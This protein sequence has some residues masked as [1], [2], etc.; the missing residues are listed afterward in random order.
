MIQRMKGPVMRRVSLEAI[1][2]MHVGIQFNIVYW[3]WF[4]LQ[5]SSI[6]DVYPEIVFGCFRFR[7][8][9]SQSGNLHSAEK[10][11]RGSPPMLWCLVKILC[12]PEC[13]R[14]LF[15]VLKPDYWVI[16]F[17]VVRRWWSTGPSSLPPRGRRG[18]RWGR[19]GSRTPRGHVSVFGPSLAE[20]QLPTLRSRPTESL[21]RRRGRRRRRVRGRRTHGWGHEPSDTDREPDEERQRRRLRV[22]HIGTT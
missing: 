12:L 5:C 20:Q 10:P 14:K 8:L 2:Y 16:V 21:Q 11:K 4:P 18:R 3:K 1:F 7:L 13:L 22:R 15:A 17:L 9:L 6:R 19:N